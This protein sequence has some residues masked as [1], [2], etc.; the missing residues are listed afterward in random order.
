MRKPFTVPTSTGKKLSQAEITAL[1]R[2][3][4]T[5]MLARTTM[6][7]G[8]MARIGTVWLATAQGM[9]DWSMARLCTMPTASRI[10]ASVPIRNP[11]SV[12][13]SVIQPCQTRLRFEVIFCPKSPS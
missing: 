9:T 13:E 8:A 1:G 10:P 3:P 5:P 2:S 4:V 6:T 11:A 12:A 7:I